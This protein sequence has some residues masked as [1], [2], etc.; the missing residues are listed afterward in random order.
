[1]VLYSENPDLPS[2]RWQAR[3]IVGHATEVLI[4]NLTSDATFHFRVQARNTIGYSPTSSNSVFY[5]KSHP[6]GKL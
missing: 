5:T 2:E 4:S 6:A 3:T 1:M